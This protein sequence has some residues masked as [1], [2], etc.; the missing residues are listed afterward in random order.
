MA[1]D[2][3]EEAFERRHYVFKTKDGRYGLL[4]RS[5]AGRY[6]FIVFELRG[7]RT[8]RVVTARDMTQRDKRLYRRKV[9]R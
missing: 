5:A 4:G 7:R 3:A 8:A 9:E 1:A 2:E 6:L